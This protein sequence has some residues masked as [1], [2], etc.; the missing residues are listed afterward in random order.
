MSLAAFNCVHLYFIDSNELHMK[1]DIRLNLL[2]DGT[3]MIHN[4]QESDQGT[5]QCM[6]KNVV[7]EATTQGVL[8][9]YFGTPS[10]KSSSLE[11]SLF[12]FIL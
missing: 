11:Y 12:L 5:Y 2:D 7:G 6:A 8:L 9:R 10:K 3:L 4:T 1:N